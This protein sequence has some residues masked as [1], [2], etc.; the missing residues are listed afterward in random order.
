MR[1]LGICNKGTP[2]I[3]YTSNGDLHMFLRKHYLPELVQDTAEAVVP[4]DDNV[5]LQYMHGTT[6]YE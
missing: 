5:I 4:I 6:D 1:L 3:I 2:F